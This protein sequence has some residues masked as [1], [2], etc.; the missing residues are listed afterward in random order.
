MAPL[1][2]ALQQNLQ[3]EACHK[4]RRLVCL[5]LNDF[6]PTVFYSHPSRCT[7]PS[8]EALPGIPSTFQPQNHIRRPLRNRVN[9][10]LNL[11]RHNNRQ[12]TR[13]TNPQPLRGHHHQFRIHNLPHRRA[14][15]E[16]I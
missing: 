9:R 8:H 16:M 14:A 4:K 3:T 13:I 5:L 11:P 7:T 6:I 10:N 15:P 2:L 12:D 1:P